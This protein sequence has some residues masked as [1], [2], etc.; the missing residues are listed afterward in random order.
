MSRADEIFAANMKDIIEN[1]LEGK[2]LLDKMDDYNIDKNVAKVR[3]AYDVYL[4]EGND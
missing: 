4:G 2:S 1:G 3:I